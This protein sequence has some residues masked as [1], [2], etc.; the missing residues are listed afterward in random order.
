[1]QTDVPQIYR[2]QG[3]L[4]RVSG[5]GR[6]LAGSLAAVCLGLLI[7]AARL[8][9]NPNGLGTH[10]ELGLD[11]CAFLERTGLPCPS[12]GMTTSFA[13]FARGNLLASI[14]VQPMGAMLAALSGMMVWAGA[15]IAITA[16]PVHRLLS[17]MRPRYHVI[18]LLVLAV[19]AWGWKIFIHLHGIDGWK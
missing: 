13:W 6:L 17:A 15:Y 10:R 19:L 2:K 14:Y 9:P 18:P 11:Q 3:P 5:W 16:R 8:T 12:C 1:L 7:T 4:A